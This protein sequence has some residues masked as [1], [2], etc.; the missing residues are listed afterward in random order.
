MPRATREYSS[1]SSFLSPIFTSSDQADRARDGLSGRGSRVV[2][3][4]VQGTKC[5]TCN[6]VVTG[7]V[8]LLLQ[9]WM[10]KPVPSSMRRSSR[11]N[12]WPL[13][14]TTHDRKTRYCNMRPLNAIAL[15]AAT[16]LS[17]CSQYGWGPAASPV[18]YRFPRPNYVTDLSYPVGN[19]SNSVASYTLTSSG[20]GNHSP[21]GIDHR[22]YASLSPTID[23]GTRRDVTEQG[24]SGSWPRGTSLDHSFLARQNSV[25]ASVGEPPLVW[26]VRLSSVAQEWA[27]HLIATGA[28]KHH[29][30][31]GYG[32]NL[33]EIIGGSATPRNVVSAWADEIRDY[34]P[35][36]NSC[37]SGVDCGHYTQIVWSTTHAVGCAFATDP[38]RQV[39]VCEYYP[40]GNVIGYR[41]Y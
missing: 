29:V 14:E 38:N 22:S 7:L 25:R 32:E 34:N 40:A 36:T 18:T 16:A 26:S 8:T 1:D 37:S 19:S 27:N 24:S 15:L 11:G 41:P 17:A 35:R 30:D 5:V 21:T 20:Y 10:S 3:R 28:F 39:W 13:P 4:T 2:P 31:G 12:V 33:Y 9:L 6:L 23:L